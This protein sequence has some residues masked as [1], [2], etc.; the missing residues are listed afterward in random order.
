MK[1]AA[2]VIA[3]LLSCFPPMV[4]FAAA[5]KNAGTGRTPAVS[6]GKLVAVKVTGTDRYT[7]KEILAASGLELAQTAGEGDF[8]EAVQRLGNTGLFSDVAYS[9][10]YSPAGTRLELQ[11]VDTDKS[12][13]VPAHYENFVWFTDAELTSE[14]QRRVPLFK[15]VLPLA[16]SLPD[17]VSE[18]LQEIL[19][20]GRLPGRVNY[21]RES[22]PGTEDLTG[23]AYRVED[24]SFYVHDAEFPGAGPAQL[25]PLK[26]AAR[27]LKGAEYVRSSLTIV[28]MVDY[29]P[30][31]HQ[32]GYLKAAFAAPEARVVTQTSTEIQVDAI[33]A[34]TPGKIYSTSGVA[35]KG[36]AAVEAAQLQ[37]LLHLP[38]GQPADAVHLAADLENVQKL[39][40]TRGYMTARIQADPLLDDATSTVHYD[41]SVVEG[42]LFQMGELEIVGLDSQSRARLQNAWTLREGQPY[43]SDYPR[44]FLKNAFRLLSSGEPW[45]AD[46]RET[47]DAKDKTVDVTLRFTAK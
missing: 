31:Y 30:V 14:I 17:Q 21:L 15:Q 19:G 16:G 33:F 11:L 26:A 44:E 28:A 1:K 18:A 43:N 38:L 34:V 36:N 41:L 6:V 45:T 35:W 32:R 47:V 5:Q 24:A 39:Y 7:E 10:S 25:P 22:K 27:K 46:I 13:L 29:L 40:H 4:S 20:A 3:W 42:D 23:I 2:L 8:K 9:Y 12:K 37:S